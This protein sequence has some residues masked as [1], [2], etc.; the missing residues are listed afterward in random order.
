MNLDYWEHGFQ[1]LVK[2]KETTG[3]C[4][5]PQRYK[6]PSGFTLGVWSRKQRTNQT[7]LDT[8]QKEK[9]D[10]LGFIWSI[11]NYEWENGFNELTQF[12]KQNG[13]C[14]V[15]STF[16]TVSGFN[17]GN[18]VRGKRKSSHL[19]K[20]QFLQL[21]QMG[22]DWNPQETRWNEAF[23]ELTQYENIYGNCLVPKRFITASGFELGTWVGN[24]RRQYLVS[25]N[26]EHSKML[27][28]LGFIWKIK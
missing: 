9:L 5:V 24:Q 4:L 23:K 7:D 6:T 2:F 19:S 17:L 21:D 13:H 11:A 25:P 16:K 28:T 15:P 18:W 12:K 14:D 27:E 26:S 3:T 1:Q 8:K 20:D 10:K 22:L